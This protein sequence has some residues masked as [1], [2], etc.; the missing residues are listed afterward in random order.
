MIGGNA[1]ADGL[2][3]ACSASARFASRTRANILSTLFCNALRFASSLWSANSLSC[4]TSVANSTASNT[5][6][7]HKRSYIF[8]SRL[9]L[10]SSVKFCSFLFPRAKI[11]FSVLLR[12]SSARW[13]MRSSSGQTT[14]SITRG[15][16]ELKPTKAPKIVGNGDCVAFKPFCK[17]AVTRGCSVAYS[18]P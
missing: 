5:F 12:I 11:L 15:P 2:R 10:S 18:S 7:A 3:V 6:S 4:N 9:V 17:V 1:P 14:V 16:N 13:T 8:S